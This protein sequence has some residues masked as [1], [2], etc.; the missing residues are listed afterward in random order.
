MRR[1]RREERKDVNKKDYKF[2]PFITEWYEKK[3]LKLT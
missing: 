3:V 1:E 2:L